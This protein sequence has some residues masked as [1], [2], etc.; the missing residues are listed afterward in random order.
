MLLG[1]LQV[2]NRFTKLLFLRFS[3]L[4]FVVIW[5]PLLPVI[6]ETIVILT[7]VTYLSYTYRYLGYV[8]FSKHQNAYECQHISPFV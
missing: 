1:E 4:P 7:S 2:K 5:E 8:M 3:A 6:F